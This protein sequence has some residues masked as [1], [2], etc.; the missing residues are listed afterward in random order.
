LPATDLPRDRTVEEAVT[1]I[2]YNTP[3]PSLQPY[4]KHV[5][6]C[7]VQNEPG[8]LSRVSGI[9]A[10]RGFNIDSLVVCSTE[11][12]DLSRMCI[13]LSGQDGV[14]EQAR[15][16]LEDLV[17]VW[18][19][20]DY[21]DTRCIE[22][23][24]LLVKVSIL[25]P[26]YLDDQLIG[27]P[28]HDPR[29]GQSYVQPIADPSAVVEDTPGTLSTNY[30]QEVAIAEQFEHGTHRAAPV[31]LTPSEVLRFKSQYLQS[32]TML[33]DQFGAKI[34]DMSDNSVIVEVSGKTTRV[35]AFLKLIKPF[36]ILESART[37][38]MVMPRT[39]I[40]SQ[41]DEQAVDTDVGG[42]DASLLPPG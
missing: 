8:V 17:P 39:P 13:V 22:R 27:G 14:V 18:A 5:L 30:E 41:T 37:G 33:A 28:S 2:L 1:N 25:G 26:D 24:L 29:R 20:L 38:A 4:K 21:T 19:V 12:R 23:E 10:A 31:P 32:I 36:G 7:L 16:Q 11:V 6:N 15:R 42:I 9:L 35:D 3:P 40:G 34:V